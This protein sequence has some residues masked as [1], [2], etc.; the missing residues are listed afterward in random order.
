MPANPKKKPGTTAMSANPKK[1]PGTEVFDPTAAVDGASDSIIEHESNLGQL[2]IP[3]LPLHER[4]VAAREILSAAC[5]DDTV[6][7]LLTISGTVAIHEETIV[8]ARIAIG[9]HFQSILHAIQKDVM[10]DGDDSPGRQKLALQ[11][12]Y[13]YIGAVHRYSRAVAR[14]HML[15]YQRFARNAEAQRLLSYSEMLLLAEQFKNDEDITLLLDEKR[16]ANLPEVDFKARAREYGMKLKQAHETIAQMTEVIAQSE[17]DFFIKSSEFQRLQTSNTELEKSLE[18]SGK[19]IQTIEQARAEVS[20]RLVAARSESQTA[21]DRVLELEAGV[22]D[23][24][25]QLD[26]AKNSP[27]GPVETKEVEVLPPEYASKLEALQAAEKLLAAKQA[28]VQAL[29]TA[30]AT[31]QQELASTEETLKDSGKLLATSDALKDLIDHFSLF[32]TSYITAR[33]KVAA[34]GTPEPFRGILMEIDSKM[35]N[36]HLEVQAAIARSA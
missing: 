23:L 8:R 4:R 35:Q 28:E 15:V 3:T 29:E 6:A 16:E 36:L 24:R 11:L 34:A 12:T 33:L 18:E 7:S 13:E 5:S 2:Q 30:A 14:N 10:A 19:K 27:N 22:A 21:Q 9:G 25:A 1:K 17:G 31:K 32:H 26:A 20:A